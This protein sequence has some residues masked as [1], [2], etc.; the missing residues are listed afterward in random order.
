M[1]K[2]RQSTREKRQTHKAK[3]LP[4]KPP[5]TRA[6]PPATSREMSPPAH[7]QHEA[8]Q[9][10]ESIAIM[11]KS[12]LDRLDKVE[13]TSNQRD[14][15][16]PTH[17]GKSSSPM[18]SDM[19]SEPSE[20]DGTENFM[21]EPSKRPLQEYG[22]LVGDDIS[23]KLIRKI[24]SDK[25]VD[26]WELLPNPDRSAQDS[27]VF[28]ATSSSDLKIYKRRQKKF[29][30]FTQWSRAFD[31]YTAVYVDKAD[32]RED[33]SI[34]IKD[35]LTYRKEVE[36]MHASGRDWFQFDHHFRTDREVNP[37]R[38]STVRHDLLRQY[39]RQNQS[40][41]QDGFRQD[42]NTNRRFSAQLPEKHYSTKNSSVPPVGYCRKYHTPDTRCQ[43]DD[44]R[45]K[46]VCPRCSKRHPMY[47]SCSRHTGR[48]QLDRPQQTDR[49]NR[50][51]QS[52]NQPRPPPPQQR[53]G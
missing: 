6:N 40:F 31:V 2:Q 12:L 9:S 52:N 53:T 49:P 8:S 15:P 44:C 39:D 36:A 21:F 38:F 47:T 48:P 14:S 18:D 27:F 20:P 3:S 32:S 13:K 33:M 7:D 23:H 11:L 16:K 42:F 22:T 30:S 37:C 1:P 4:Q 28:S 29:I 17:S 24:R 50:P 10:D 34:L 35:L 26:F 45:Y 43:Y 46:H 51:Q 25:F 19:E 5:R 41:R